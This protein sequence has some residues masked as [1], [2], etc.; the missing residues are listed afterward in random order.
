MQVK[1]FQIKGNQIF[2]I[3]PDALLRRP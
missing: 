1:T 2:S 3:D